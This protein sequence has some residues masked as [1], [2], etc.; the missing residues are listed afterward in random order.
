MAKK[1]EKQQ[2]SALDQVRRH[3]RVFVDMG[4]AAGES[5]DQNRFLDQVVV[6]VARAV[7]ID[8]VKVLRYRRRE[9]DLLVAAGFMGSAAACLLNRRR[10]IDCSDARS[11]LYG[12]PPPEL[13]L[14]LLTDAIDG[15]GTI[16]PTR[17]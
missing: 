6:Q 9:T 4:R 16:R 2:A 10:K 12:R 17:R 3:V 7:E 5:S 11:L 15:R 1:S 13:A 8:H 14:T